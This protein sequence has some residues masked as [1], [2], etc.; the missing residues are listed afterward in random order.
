MKTIQKITQRSLPLTLSDIAARVWISFI[1]FKAFAN[2]LMILY[3][4][5]SIKST[6]SHARILASLVETCAIRGTVLVNCALGSAVRRC[7]KHSWETRAN[8]SI[9]VGIT[10]R[11]RPTRGWHAWVLMRLISC[12]NKKVFMREK[13]T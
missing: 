9:I 4:A 13:S 11:I 3:V 2:R 10:L 5:E 12:C 8:S 1:S 7:S 6:R